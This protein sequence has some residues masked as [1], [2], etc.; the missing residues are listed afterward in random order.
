[1]TFKVI[2]IVH[3]TLTYLSVRH[4]DELNVIVSFFQ[5]LNYNKQV[6][7]SSSFLASFFIKIL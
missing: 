4:V 6:F 1:M 2:I 7:N 5:M 3:L